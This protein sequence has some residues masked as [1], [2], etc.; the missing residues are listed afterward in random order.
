M[1]IVLIRIYYEVFAPKAVLKTQSVELPEIYASAY[2]DDCL[3]DR[4]RGDKRHQELLPEVDIYLRMYGKV[5]NYYQQMLLPSIRFFWKGYISLLIVLDGES[6]DDR[7][8]GRI[9]QKEYPYPK[10]CFQGAIDPEIYHG[11]GHERMQ[12][13]FFYPEKFTSRKYVGFIDTDTV[14][15]TKLTRNLFFENGKPIVIGVYGPA[16][17]PFWSSMSELTADIF[18]SKEV[19]KCM[20]YFPVIIKVEHIIKLRGYLEALHLKPFDEIYKEYSKNNFG[21]FNIMCQYIWKFHR[22]EYAFYF[23]RRTA[24]WNGEGNSPGREY[25][26]F[27]DVIITPEQTIPRIR[28]SIH[29]RHITT[30]KWKQNVTLRNILKTGL[31]FSGGFDQCPDLCQGLNRTALHRELFVFEGSNWMWDDRCL[32]E[33]NKHYRFVKNMSDKDTF[34]VIKKACDEVN[35]LTFNVVEKD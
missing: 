21:Q 19:V 8:L 29:Y 13:D 26:S 34:E 12:R 1:F 23:H 24:Q 11:I 9:L 20:S 2:M 10:V 18:Q 31:C 30:D 35:Y 28:T 7:K 22:N 3:E 6:I 5:V 33:Q 25:P 17:D 14:F 16:S 4:D 15:V 27:Y 32:Q